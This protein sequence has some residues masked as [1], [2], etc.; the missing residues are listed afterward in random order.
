MITLIVN[1]YL[2]NE[3]VELALG[4]A[5]G[6]SYHEDLTLQRSLL[7]T[8]YLRIIKC[9]MWPK[10]RIK[11]RTHG[12]YAFRNVVCSEWEYISLYTNFI[13]LNT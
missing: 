8:T 12:K 1:Q 4:A 9:K 11:H 6:G 5:I 10:R 7:A 3:R 2:H 13:L